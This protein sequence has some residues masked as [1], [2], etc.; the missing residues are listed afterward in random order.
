MNG[1]KNLSTMANSVVSTQERCV[2]AAPFSFGELRRNYIHTAGTGQ[3]VI[4]RRHTVHT[5]RLSLLFHF[6]ITPVIDSTMKFSAAV[7]LSA[8]A[9]AAAYDVPSLTPEN[10]DELTDGKTV[11]LK[12]FA[13][14]VR[15]IRA[16]RRIV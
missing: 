15:Q 2:S 11:F 7:L 8:L 10:Y 16:V 5:T 3:T 14:W 6:S 9:T 4:C 12:F 13:P 1:P